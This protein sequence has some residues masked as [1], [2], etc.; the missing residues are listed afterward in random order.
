MG[1]VY[2]A[3]VIGHP[4][5]GH[6]WLSVNGKIRQDGDINQMIWKLPEI[7]AH[8]ST[9]FELKA[10]DL[11]FTGTPAGVGPVKKGDVLEGGVDGIATLKVRVG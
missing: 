1:P 6:L 4:K 5:S 7:I 8:L 9:Q 3:S 11:I 2:P 10:G